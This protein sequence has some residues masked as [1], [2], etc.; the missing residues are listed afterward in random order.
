MVPLARASPGSIESV[1]A[2]FLI[3]VSHFLAA[4]RRLP[5][6]K[7][8]GMLRSS[9]DTSARARATAPAAGGR[10]L[11]SQLAGSPRELGY[12]LSSSAA[13]AATVTR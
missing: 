11:S 6:I 1:P 13:A 2:P 9:A 8:E 5:R 3:V 4:N 12:V 10:T 7:S